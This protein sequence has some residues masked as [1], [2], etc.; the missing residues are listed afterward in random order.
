MDAMLGQ[1][2]SSAIEESHSEDTVRLYLRKIRVR[3]RVG[4]DQRELKSSGVGGDQREWRSS[5]LFEESWG[6]S[7]RVEGFGVD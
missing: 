5:A 4:G 1:L 2:W 3:K 7:E 6:R